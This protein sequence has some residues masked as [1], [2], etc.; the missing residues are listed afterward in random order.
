MKLQITYAQTDS[1][2]GDLIK[3]TPEREKEC[4]LELYTMQN[5]Q[6]K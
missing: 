1:L 5:F 2:L 3:K 6:L 4:P